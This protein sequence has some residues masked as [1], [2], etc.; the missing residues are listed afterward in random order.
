MGNNDDECEEEIEDDGEELKA[1]Y[2]SAPNEYETD[3]QFQEALAEV[4]EDKTD[5]EGFSDSEG[6]K[7]CSDVDDE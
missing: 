7:S 5:F 6:S 4:E 2:K 3:D 1:Y